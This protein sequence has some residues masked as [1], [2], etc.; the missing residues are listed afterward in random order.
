MDEVKTTV[1]LIDNGDGAKI[2]D[3][4][5]DIVERYSMEV[6]KEMEAEDSE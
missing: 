5:H 2:K 4:A 1:T 3:L 6:L